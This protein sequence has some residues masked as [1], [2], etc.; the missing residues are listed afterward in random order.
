MARGRKKKE[1]LSDEFKNVVASLPTVEL[2]ER[3]CTLSKQEMDVLKA[4]ADDYKLADAQAL[5]KEL[6]AP[7]K[8]SVSLL[9]A[10]RNYV[11]KTLEERGSAI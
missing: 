5:S 10:Q 6:N 3:V 7:Y 9:R 11:L 2:K 1:V 8:E 4:K